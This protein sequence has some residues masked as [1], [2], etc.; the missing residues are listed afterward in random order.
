M[1]AMLLAAFVINIVVISMSASAKSSL[2]D[3]KPKTCDPASTIPAAQA[4]ASDRRLATDG[5]DMEDNKITIGDGSVFCG[6]LEFVDELY[7]TVLNTILG[8]QIGVLVIIIFSAVYWT[9]IYRKLMT[10]QGYMVDG[11][12]VNRIAQLLAIVVMAVGYLLQ[13]VVYGMVVALE[14]S[15]KF[16]AFNWMTDGDKVYFK[17]LDL[18]A[19]SSDGDAMVDAKKYSSALKSLDSDITT[20]H[21][22]VLTLIILKTLQLVLGH[23]W[24]VSMTKQD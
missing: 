8:S 24:A 7:G 1:W 20:L 16:T 12:E 2:D 5:P 15:A 22:L 9:F 11:I 13:F 14:S 10:M 4:G 21:A 3:L 17:D 23:G 19:K 18:N 6:T